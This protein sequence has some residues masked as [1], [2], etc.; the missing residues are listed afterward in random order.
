M[1]L[2]GLASLPTDEAHGNGTKPPRSERV[3]NDTV[4]HTK[5][6]TMRHRHHDEPDPRNE[7]E[8]ATPHGI[9]ENQQI[10]DVTHTVLVNLSGKDNL[11][12]HRTLIVDPWKTPPVGP[13]R[14]TETSSSDSAR[15]Q[16]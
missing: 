4:K 1:R 5:Q 11:D 7:G 16:H 10:A 14:T 12:D 15:L 13:N 9:Q 6:E 2:Q 8:R 3:E